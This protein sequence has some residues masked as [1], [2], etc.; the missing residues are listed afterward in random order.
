MRH[1]QERPNTVAVEERGDKRIDITYSQLWSLARKYAFLI[2]E[3]G[4]PVILDFSK[5]TDYVASLLGCWMRNAFPVILDPAWPQER[6]EKIYEN[7][8]SPIVA[9][10]PPLETSEYLEPSLYPPPQQPAY[11]I[12]SSGSTGLPKGIVVPHERLF[13]LFQEQSQILNLNSE[14]RFL[15]LHN[16]AFDASIAD[17]GVTLTAGA[18]LCIDQQPFL[19]GPQGFLARVAELQISHIDIPPSLLSL[20]DS[21][22]APPCLKSL[23]IGGEVCSPKTIELWSTRLNLVNV[24]G[25]TEATICTSMIKCQTDWNPGSIGYPLPGINYHLDPPNA[26]QGEL[27]ISGPGLALNYWNNPKLSSERFPIIDNQRFFRTRDI[28]KRLGTGEYIFLGR[29]DRQFKKN[30]LLIC[31]EEVENA[32]C[33]HP[34]VT[35]AHVFLKKAQLSA[36]IETTVSSDSLDLRTHLSRQLPSWMIPSHWNY[37]PKFPQLSNNKIDRNSLEEILPLSPEASSLSSSS[38]DLILKAMRELLALPDLTPDDDFFAQG[39]DSLATIQLLARCDLLELPLCSEVLFHHRTARSIAANLEKT[40]PGK[41]SETLNKEA[42]IIFSN[43]SL[44]TQKQILPSSPACIF[45]TGATGF[46]GRALLPILLQETSAQIYCLIRNS[47]QLQSLLDTN[48]KHLQRLHPLI[49]ELTQPQ[50]GLTS[51]EWNHLATEC[52]TIIHLAADLHSLH[53]FE[54]LQSTNLAGTGR[55]LELLTISSPKKLLYASTLSVFVDALPLPSLCLESD[56]LTSATTVF[57][58]YAQ[59]K[60]ASEK[61]VSKVR[62]SGHAIEIIRY[63]LLTP[64]RLTGQAPSGDT[65]T[66]LLRQTPP[67]SPDPQLGIDLTPVDFAA[68][69]TSKILFNKAPPRTWHLANPTPLSQEKLI[70]ARSESA[71][72]TSPLTS[73]QNNLNDETSLP[74]LLNPYKTTHI[75]FQTD[76]L[77]ELNLGTPLD[78]SKKSL[79]QYFNRIHQHL[80]HD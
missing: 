65:L 44:S 74:P 34:S 10:P 7:F 68:E 36:C 43:L 20:L 13:S 18:T 26:E 75:R 78:L 1:S 77:Q 71:F 73:A 63:G 79:V 70:E 60:Y 2:P 29:S 54:Q 67:L 12:H 39:A 11:I 61:L 56:Q 30:G 24:Y 57:G 6:K 49:G 31:P 33:S 5:G 17:I 28:V 14:D 35:N 50:L 27:L 22:K 3:E 52:D 19:H 46:L 80:T 45:L 25:P 72:A 15:W 8:S 59:S 42:E 76:N 37:L 51:Q 55:I 40:T 64:S 16:Q 58:G 69:A 9:E 4:V 23:L 48:H 41:S 38:E 21:S 66:K 53:S 62:D 47:S 32:L